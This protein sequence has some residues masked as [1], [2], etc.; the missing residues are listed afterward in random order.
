MRDA[1]GAAATLALE[2]ASVD[3]AG[4]PVLR[5]ISLAVPAGGR[6]AL[7]GRNGAGKTTTLR[8]L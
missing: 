3:I 7:I 1:P 2:G 5:G 8:A 6:V 4:V